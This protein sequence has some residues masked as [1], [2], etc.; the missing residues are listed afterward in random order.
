[1]SKPI[2]A[3]FTQGFSEE[4]PDCWRCGECCM[5]IPVEIKK[6]EIELISKRLKV[7]ERRL[8]IESITDDFDKA[9][10]L[11]DQWSEL[12]S[13][14]G[15]IRAPC[16][17]LDWEV[18]HGKK[19]AHCKIY[20]IRPKECKIFFCGR[21]SPDEPLSPRKYVFRLSGNQ[22]EVAERILAEDRQRF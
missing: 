10:V 2:Y 18:R 8:F 16:L 6:E 4:K 15:W 7:S 11:P 20:K 9:N 21:D 14:E 3:S 17:F 5:I 22:V 19:R 12:I 13:G 1:M